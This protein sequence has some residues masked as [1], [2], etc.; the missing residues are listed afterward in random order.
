LNSLTPQEATALKYCWTFWARENQLEPLGDWFVWLILAGRGYGKSRAGA[1]WVRAKAEQF[2]GC[3][4]ALIGRTAADYRQVMVEGES[5]IL[6][7]CPPWNRPAFNPSLRQLRWPNGSI[8]TCYSGDEPNLLR[9]PQH[10]FCWAD[11][12]ASWRYPEE[13]WSNLLMGLRLG[14]QPKVCATTTPRPTKFIRDL[15]DSKSTHITRGSTYDNLSNLAPTFREIIARYEGTTLGRQELEGVI[16]ADIAGTLWNQSLTAKAHFSPERDD[17]GTRILPR[18][19]RVVVSVDPAVSNNQNSDYTGIIVAG[20]GYDG[21][22]YVIEDLTL[23]GS[24]NEWATT[25]VNAYH[26]YKADRI[27]AEVNQ[28]GDLVE[29]ALRSVDKSVS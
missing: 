7:I 23:K 24:P 19:R 5:G 25:A 21:L 20:I 15:A 6:A 8:A 26:S 9:G 12:I 17:S 28:G 11:E 22:G 27:I 29:S 10:H 18:F 13:T 16:L 4:I 1:E 14:R 3:R 2:P